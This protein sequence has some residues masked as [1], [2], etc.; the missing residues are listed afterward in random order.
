MIV[1]EGDEDRLAAA[2]VRAVQRVADPAGVAAVSLEPAEHRRTPVGARP[3]EPERGEVA[4]Q[5]PRRGRPPGVRGQY[6]R[7]L[8]AKQRGRL[9]RAVAAQIHPGP[10]GPEPVRVSR[11]S[12]DRRCPH[13]EALASNATRSEAADPGGVVPPRATVRLWHARRRNERAERAM[14]GS[15]VSAHVLASCSREDGPTSI[16]GLRRSVMLGLELVWG[17]LYCLVGG[18]GAFR[19]SG[20]SGLRRECLRPYA[21]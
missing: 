11:A 16:P 10:F 14:F 8:S 12:L 7:D 17:V 2:D 19:W 4:L 9:V 20:L 18:V 13:P 1:E 21:K 5:G 6:H 15:S 3:V